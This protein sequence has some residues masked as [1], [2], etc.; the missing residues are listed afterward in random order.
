MWDLFRNEGE[1]G[2]KVAE[3]KLESAIQ[4]QIKEEK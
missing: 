4:R 1:T 3:K 2:G